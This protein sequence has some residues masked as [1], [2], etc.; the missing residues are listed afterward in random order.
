MKW[1][2][3]GLG[4]TANCAIVMAHLYSKGTNYGMF[5]FFVQ[6]RDWDTHQP[7]PGV[8][9]GDIGPKIGLN[10]VDN[11]FL[12]FYRHRIPRENMLMGNAEILPDGTFH[13]KTKKKKATYSTMTLVRTTIVYA[14]GSMALAAATTIGIR[15]SAV[16]RQSE[17]KPGEP[18]PQVMDYQTQQY[19]LYPY[20]AMAYAFRFVAYDLF[21]L[22]FQV[23]YGA[24]PGDDSLMAETHALSSG[25]KAHCTYMAALGIEQARRD[26]GEVCLSSL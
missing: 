26:A 15:Y 8:I 16:R 7:I 5:P 21:Q 11:G 9:S 10:S 18:E 17:L 14:F 1:W 12:K 4:K 6:I 22:F 2:P 19:K 24:E 23:M 3:G 20:L 13:Q 25:L